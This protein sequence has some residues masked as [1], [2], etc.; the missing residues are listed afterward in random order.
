V[1]ITKS[2]GTVDRVETWVGAL[3]AREGRDL[4]AVSAPQAAAYL[5]ALAQNAEAGAK[6]IF[7]AVLA[8][9]ARTWPSLLTIARDERRTRST[10][11]E[12]SFWLSRFAAASAAGHPDDITNDDDRTDKDELKTHAIFV[13]SQLPRNEGVPLLLDAARTNGNQHV[14]SAALFWLGQSG[15]SR[16]LDLFESLMRK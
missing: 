5:V 7:P 15:D 16:A 10:R 12:A 13:V 3:R 1:R 2:D 14:R 8:D 6:A 4:G 11:Q 9:S